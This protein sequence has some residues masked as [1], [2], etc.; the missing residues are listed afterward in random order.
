MLSMTNYAETVCNEITRL[1]ASQEVCDMCGEY[2][3]VIYDGTTGEY[4]CEDC[5]EEV[6]DR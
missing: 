5:I 2:K 4:L 6:L 1:F 3:E